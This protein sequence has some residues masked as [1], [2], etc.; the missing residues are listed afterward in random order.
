MVSTVNGT[1]WQ[2][3]LAMA[4]TLFGVVTSGGTGLRHCA[5]LGYTLE[6]AL[7]PVG[8]SDRQSN[9]RLRALAPS[10]GDES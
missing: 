2:Y 8:T 9:R 1:T 6:N 10:M 4:H 5:L 3:T 7:Y